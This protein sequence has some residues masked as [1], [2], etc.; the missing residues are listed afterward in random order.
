VL[1]GEAVDLLERALKLPEGERADLAVRLL[2]S[3][4]PETEADRQTAWDQEIRRRIED[5]DSG[6]VKP[7]PWREA[8]RRILGSHK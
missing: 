4:D 7:V 6:R 3:L 2:D 8:R 1:R 5:L